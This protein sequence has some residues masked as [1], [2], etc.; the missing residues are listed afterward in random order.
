MA[1]LAREVA[2]VRLTVATAT[3]MSQAISTLLRHAL[4]GAQQRLLRQ[5]D[6]EQRRR[7]SAV[8]I[9]PKITGT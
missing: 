2:D 3:D 7:L 8:R 6:P 9:L 4:A 5:S 1:E